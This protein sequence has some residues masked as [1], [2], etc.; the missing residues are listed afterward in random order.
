M[1]SNEEPSTP[2]NEQDQEIKTQNA[3]QDSP[4][5]QTA[6]A[7]KLLPKVSWQEVNFAFPQPHIQFGKGVSKDIPKAVFKLLDPMLTHIKKAQ[8]IKPK[9]MIVIGNKSI[10][11]HGILDPIIASCDQNAIDTFVYSCGRGEATVTMVD[12]GLEIALQEKPHYIAGIGGGSVLDVAKAIGGIY[13]NGGIAEDYHEGKPFELP[14]L[15]FIAVPTTSGTGTEITNNSVLI[16]KVRGFKRSIRGNQIIAKYILL[17]PALTISCPPEVTAYSG[18]DA[19][20]QAIEAY[21]SIHSHPLADTYALQAIKM[22]SRNLF[23][24]FENGENFDARAE[25]MLG[26]FYAGIAFSNVGLG[27]V[28]AFAHPIGF[29][30]N[31]PHGKVCGSL[32]PWVIEYNLEY[33]E[34]K[35]AKITKLLSELDLFTKFDP[36]AENFENARR[37][38]SMIKELFAQ[39]QIPLRLQNLGIQKEDF[40]WIIENTKGA[41]AANNPRPIDPD[42]LM[43]LLEHAW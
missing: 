34:D 27:L 23:S 35:Y 43:E 11:E 36:K 8:I 33:R 9:L 2:S 18:A 13:T 21:V 31:L 3:D 4:D 19:L 41:S 25:M 30:Y 37:L 38:S 28:H 12:E 15:P 26:S 32:L 39:V 42:S 16:D 24:V 22:I 7:T 40:Q 10:K 1:N 17:D 5:A 14:G 6:E 20:V 29:K